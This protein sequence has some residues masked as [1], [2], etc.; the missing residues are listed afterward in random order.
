MLVD[1]T[2]QKNTWQ[3]IQLCINVKCLIVTSNGNLLIVNSRDQSTM[4]TEF[5]AILSP[6]QYL[7]LVLPGVPM[8]CGVV[9][10]AIVY[11]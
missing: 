10:E 11:F 1:E 9:L 6:L 8:N 4:I 5:E 2:L 7:V 3:E